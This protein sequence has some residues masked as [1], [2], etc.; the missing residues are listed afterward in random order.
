[1][2]MGTMPQDDPV[3]RFGQYGGPNYSLIWFSSCT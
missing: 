3:A 1:M 2:E